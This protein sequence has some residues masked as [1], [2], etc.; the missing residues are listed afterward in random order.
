MVVVQVKADDIY[1]TLPKML[2]QD[3]TPQIMNWTDHY[4]NERTRKLSV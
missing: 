4:Q 2:K 1:K 3:L